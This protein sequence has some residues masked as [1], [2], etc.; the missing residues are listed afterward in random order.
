MKRLWIAVLMMAFLCV[1]IFAVNAH[2]A[3]QITASWTASVGPNLDHEDLV[4]GD[5]VVKTVPAG[6]DTSYLGTMPT[7]NG[8]IVKV[9]SYNTQG[10]PNAGFVLGTLT[11]VLAPAPATGGSLIYIWKP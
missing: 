1:G 6:G 4:I 11:P 3:W 8:E 5:T 2:A 10:V 9:I 7:I